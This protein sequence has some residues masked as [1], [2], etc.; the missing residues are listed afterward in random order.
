MKQGDAPELFQLLYGKNELWENLW[1]DRK[2]SENLEEFSAL[3]REQVS[4]NQN[5]LPTS[6]VRLKVSEKISA[7]VQL[8]VDV[9]NQSADLELMSLYLEEAANL[10]NFT[11]QLNHALKERGIVRLNLWTFDIPSQR[12][13][14][15]KLPL[16]QK[17]HFSGIYRTRS[18]R[19]DAV[20]YMFQLD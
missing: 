7:L 20:I 10:Q 13:I 4:K 3:I 18:G 9:V 11:E 14:Q 19:C 5:Q 15:L 17:A 16:I 2:I 12:E 6:V 1:V 8:K